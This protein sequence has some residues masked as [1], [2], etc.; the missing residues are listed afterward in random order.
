MPQGNAGL[1]HFVEEPR[2]ELRMTKQDSK[3]QTE[4][5]KGSSETVGNS[6]LTGSK[7]H[8]LNP[9][10]KVKN[11]ESCLYLFQSRYLKESIS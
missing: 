4:A 9:L 2:S 1:Q 6:Y 11:P 10:S 5:S 7:R 8:Y 3:L